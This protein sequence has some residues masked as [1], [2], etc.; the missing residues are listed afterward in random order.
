MPCLTSTVSQI[1][2]EPIIQQ[3]ESTLAT[4]TT[5]EDLALELLISLG[6]GEAVDGIQTSCP[7][8]VRS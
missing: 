8:E 2:K 7:E 6:S 4:G 1:Y 5:A 3:V